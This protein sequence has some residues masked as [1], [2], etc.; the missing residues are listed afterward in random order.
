MPMSAPVGPI[1]TV[2]QNLAQLIA[3][4]KAWQEWTGLRNAAK[5]I[6]RIHFAELQPRPAGDEYGKDELAAERPFCVIN[7]APEDG[8]TVERVADGISLLF[9]PSGNL[10]AMFEDQVIDADTHDAPESNRKFKNHLGSVLSDM[11]DLPVAPGRLRIMAMTVAEIARE[12][13]DHENDLGDAWIA[14]VL[15]NW[16]V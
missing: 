14:T 13:E 3:D 9:K 12:A 11:Q 6:D 16:S 10:I 2:E 7:T 4:T 1:A 15:I 8:Y 5:A